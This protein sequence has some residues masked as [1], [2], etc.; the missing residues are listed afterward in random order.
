MNYTKGEWKQTKYEGCRHIRIGAVDSSLGYESDVHIAY[1][2]GATETEAN[3]NLI[4]KSPQ[5]AE[6]LVKL[7]A[8]GFNT[9]DENYDELRPILEDA[10][11]LI[12]TLALL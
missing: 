10:R 5:M 3:A 6:L 7:L 9:D 11:E 2:D 8:I 4:A 12:Y 1:V